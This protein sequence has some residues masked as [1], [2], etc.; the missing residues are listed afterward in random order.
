[1]DHEPVAHGGE[2][3]ALLQEESQRENGTHQDD[4]NQ[5]K[6]DFAPQYVLPVALLAALAMAST[7]AT[8]YFAFATLLCKDPRRC[9]GT[10]TSNYA[11]AV[12]AATSSANILGTFALGYLQKLSTRNRKRGLLLWMICRSMSAVVLV[13]GVYI[14]NIFVALSARIFEGLASDNLLHFSLNALYAQSSDKKTAS[15]LISYSL[16]LYMVGISV[17]PFIAGLLKDFTMSFFMA[18][19]FFV[20]AVSYLQIC[21]PK[22]VSEK[23]QIQGPENRG[24]VSERMNPEDRSTTQRAI[25]ALKK[26][27]K[28]GISPLLPF[29]RRPT[30]LFIGFSLCSYNVVQSYIFDALLVH[31]SI[32]FGFSAKENGLIITIVH[33]IAATYVFASLY[34]VSR[35]ISR[36][37]ARQSTQDGRSRPQAKERDLT[38]ATMSLAVQCVSLMFLGFADQ[39]AH[40]YIITVFLAI[41]LPTPSFIKAYFM[42]LFKVLD[43]PVALAALGMMETLG[44]VIGPLLLGSLQGYFAASGV[45]FFAAAGLAA[46]SLV[47]LCMGAW[48]IIFT[49]S[50]V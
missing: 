15:S 42:S 31:T 17:S 46:T 33:S 16:A 2:S 47:L 32:K 35:V 36:L 14:K 23:R 41:G 43:R 11:K 13:I 26:A 1:M 24:L 8:A 29:R 22:G 50:A 27:L 49:T 7:A 28:T 4:V 39:V 40:I 10:E 45:V 6:Q 21:L 20:I 44:S 19:G 9:E 3:T 18:L 25:Y 38:L 12:A 48:L 37:R 34:L 30:Y 5:I